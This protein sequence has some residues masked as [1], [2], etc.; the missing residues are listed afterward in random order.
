MALYVGIDVSKEKFDACGIG[1]EGKK[2]FSLSCSMNR[3]GFDKF[4]LQL[5]ARSAA[6]TDRQRPLN[7]HRITL[8]HLCI[9][10][11]LSR[12]GRDAS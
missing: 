2:I 3:E 8:P 10:S 11:T 4:V 1:D 6:S 9:R 7:G 12:M 5:A